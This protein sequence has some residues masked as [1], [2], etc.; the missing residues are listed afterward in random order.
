MGMDTWIL[1]DN[2]LT[3]TFVFASF[4]A[5]MD[6]MVRAGGVIGEMDHH[7]RWTNVYNRVEVWLCTHDAGDIVTQKDYDLAAALDAVFAG[8]QRN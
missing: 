6:F 8:D 3:K 4:E 7:P 2:Q 5:A 1:K